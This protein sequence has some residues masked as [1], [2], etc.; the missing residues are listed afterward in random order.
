[1]SS[2]LYLRI[3][4]SIVMVTLFIVT[5]IYSRWGYTLLIGIVGLFMGVE[6]R[7][8]TRKT[9]YAK[10]GLILFMPISC[11]LYLRFFYNYYFALLYFFGIWATDTFA[12]FGGKTFGG[13]KLV[14]KISPLKTWSGLLCGCI[15]SAM[16]WDMGYYYFELKRLSINPLFY[17]F[18]NG[19]I[20]QAS[21]I[22]VSYF[23]RKSDI[24]DSGNLIPG[25]GGFLDRFD[26]IIFS[27]PFLL[28]MLK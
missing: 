2:Q 6:W 26:S 25:H 4:S 24:K 11:L 7:R 1:M 16:V 9:K 3:L 5:T 27:A 22:F 18:I 15:A 21:D 10:Y 19:L 23:K 17:G 12:M 8:M 28:W 20:A 13:P 14:R